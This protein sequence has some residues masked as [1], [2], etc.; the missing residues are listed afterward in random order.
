[1]SQ[2]R[3]MQDILDMTPEEKKDLER[4]AQRAILTFVGIKVGVAVG[5]VV[6]VRALNRYA[7]KLEAKAN[8]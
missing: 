5:T 1:M 4:K 3:T 2:P 6:L 7:E 8:M